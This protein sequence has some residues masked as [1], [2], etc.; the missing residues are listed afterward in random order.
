MLPIASSTSLWVRVASSS[1]SSSPCP[2][3]QCC[4]EL[5]WVESF[6]KLLGVALATYRRREENPKRELLLRPQETACPHWLP[7]RSNEAYLGAQDMFITHYMHH[8]GDLF[9]PKQKVGSG[10]RE[11]EL[12][13]MDAC[14]ASG[15]KGALSSATLSKDFK[16]T[17]MWGTKTATFQNNW[18]QFGR[19]CGGFKE[20][21]IQICQ[22]KGAG[23]AWPLTV[24][25]WLS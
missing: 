5:L 25:D 19:P 22:D 13:S 2:S 17:D 14:P 11:W 18:L 3:L 6:W 16:G 24:V 23:L 21:P 1:S 8:L 12:W 20:S 15:I 4:G 10:P 7:T 9:M